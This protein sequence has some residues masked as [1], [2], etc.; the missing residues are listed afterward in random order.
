MNLLNGFGWH[1]IGRAK[2]N[3]VLD[4]E[5][6]RD[7]FDHRFGRKVGYLRKVGQRN[8]VARDGRRFWLTDEFA[9][10]SV[11]LK[12]H[13][14]FR[15]QVEETFRLLKQEFGWGKNQVG[16]KK[17]QIAHLHLGLYALCVVQLKAENQT[18]YQFKENLFREQIPTQ[19]QF[20]ELFTVTA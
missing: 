6:I 8:L 4:K 11:E 14:S 12:R 16:T 2:I 19:Q 15:Q 10:T 5:K 13:Y 3:R 20:I 7:S 17:A 9:L 1:Y 18:V